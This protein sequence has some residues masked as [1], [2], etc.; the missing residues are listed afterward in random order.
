MTRASPEWEEQPDDAL[1]A[2]DP[3]EE[4]PR[5][6]AQDD[7]DD[8]VTVGDLVSGAQRALDRA[9]TTARRWVDRGRFRKVRVSRNGK[10]VMPDI[11]VAA[12]AAAE[13]ATFYSVG[14]AGFSRVLAAH[15]GAKLLFDIEIVNEADRYFHVGVERFLEGDLERAEDALLRAV[16][17]DD[18]HAAAYLQLG[19]LYRMR[20]EIERARPVL[21]RAVRLDPAGDFG[22]KAGDILRA[23]DDTGARLG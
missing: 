21:E 11:P 6:T 16:H 17:I 10:A 2:R 5:A 18:T 12:V 4:A 7:V 15:I 22:R 1:K 14:M 23:L 3:A 13:A 19:V 8:V 9:G 20:R